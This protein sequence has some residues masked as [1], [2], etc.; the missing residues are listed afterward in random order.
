MNVNFLLGVFRDSCVVSRQQTCVEYNKYLPTLSQWMF[1]K[2]IHTAVDKFPHNHT[3][4]YIIHLRP[5]FMSRFTISYCRPYGISNGSIIFDRAVY[6]MD[7]LV[8]YILKTSFWCRCITSMH[9]LYR[10]GYYSK[11]PTVSFSTTIRKY[12]DWIIFCDV[13]IVYNG[14]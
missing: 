10:Q 7:Y 4:I 2:S 8:K 5:V 9:S 11:W 6:I 13:R 3:R 1:L 14:N 12:M